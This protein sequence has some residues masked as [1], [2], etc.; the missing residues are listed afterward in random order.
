[1]KTWRGMA[2]DFTA[3]SD[4]ASFITN[5]RF[6][7]EGELC[8]RRALQSALADSSKYGLIMYGA[9]SSGQYVIYADDAGNVDSAVAV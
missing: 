2:L 5:S 8:R 3:L 6:Y 9:P 7:I 4:G 1:M